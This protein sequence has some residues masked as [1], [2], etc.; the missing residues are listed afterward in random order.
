M[1]RLKE[2]ELENIELRKQVALL[3][4]KVSLLLKK[5]EELSHPKTSDNSS[6]S[7]SHDFRRR[8][9]KSLRKSSG[10]KSGGQKGHKGKTLEKSSTPTTVIPLLPSYSCTHCGTSLAHT[11]LTLSSTRQVVD[12]PPLTPIYTEYAQYSC[13]CPN[14]HSQEKASYPQGIEAPIQYGSSIQSL[15]S[16]LSVYQ[17]LPYARM[18]EL[19]KDLFH[20]PLSEG[21]VQNILER[22][23]SH[24]K[25]I[26]NEIH[27][28]LS[29]SEV[30]GADE[31]GI[32]VS[33]KREWLW[34]WQNSDN[35]YLTASPSRGYKVIA[36]EW[37]KGFP[38]ATLV[39]DRWKA[40]LKT[41]AKQHQICLAHL[42]RDST[43]II[44][45][46]KH[47]FPNL[48]K[49]FLNDIFI[50]KRDNKE[51]NKEAT[52]IIEEQLNSLLAL[53]IDKEKYPLSYTLQ[54]E[55]ISLRQMILPCLYNPRI[56]PDNNASER[57]VRNAKVK[58]KISGMFKT[59]QNA[60][61]VIRSV[62]DTMKKR[63]L[64]VLPTISHILDLDY[65]CLILT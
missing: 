18:T 1:D 3:T 49:T 8:N 9:S 50:F 34:A 30:V 40:Q 23:S 5:V 36:N 4:E 61:C 39:T 38:L 48:F 47:S 10:R 7:P 21:T 29:T 64:K 53:A 63:G 12:I 57:A 43:Y 44:E 54:K 45:V 13:T 41:P 6:M 16:Y 32:K 42:L 33:G 46:E 19:F 2:L 65:H 26:Y 31:T 59:G 60:F 37:E 56:P 62:V 20:I 27:E 28:Q 15:V 24:M 35:T 14:C 11:E 58:M 25:F 51:G 52:R 22:S 55:M 17:Y